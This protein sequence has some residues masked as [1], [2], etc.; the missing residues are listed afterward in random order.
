MH[1]ERVIPFW[2]LLIVLTMITLA[3]PAYVGESQ[4]AEQKV[5]VVNGTVINQAE[6]DS[7]MNRVLERLQR[8]GRFPNDIER[9]QIKNQV[10]E[11][12]I[13]RELLYQESQKKGIKVDQK[14]IEAQLTALKG[15]FPSEAEFKN[16][17]STMNLT[18]AGLRFQFE[19]DLAIRKL[20]DDQIGGKSTVSEKESRAYY[21]G[22]LESF[23]KPEQVRA[24]HILIK[25]DPGADEAKKAEARTKIESLQAKLKNGEDFGA[26]AKE[27]SEGPSGPKGGDLGFFGRG[28]MVKPFE[29]TAFSM[30]PGQVSG[31][32]ETRFGYHLIMVTERTPESTLSYEEV[33]DRLEQYLKQQ[34]VQEEIAAYVETLKGKAKIERLVKEG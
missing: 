12:L 6:F 21:D 14:E 1:I 3:S 24:S 19:R 2:R 7:E 26:L 16:A 31:M 5:A 8:T 25:V 34:K 30:K 33:K 20:L 23:K 28:Q 11:N 32:V 18:E 15:R 10:L 9:S 29:E 27:Y 17:L 4:S 22:N 13:A